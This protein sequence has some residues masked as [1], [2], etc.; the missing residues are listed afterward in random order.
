[1]TQEVQLMGMMLMYSNNVP[2]FSMILKK[3]SAPGNCT[4]QCVA[5][6][7]FSPV[8]NMFTRVRGW[9]GHAEHTD[10]VDWVMFCTVKYRK[11]N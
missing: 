3:N 8:S 6:N 1:M 9:C 2:L 10:V 5:L 4:P 7:I 11:W